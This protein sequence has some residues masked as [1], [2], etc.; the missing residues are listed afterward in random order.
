MTQTCVTLTHDT[1]PPW[2]DP[3]CTVWVQR[4]AHNTVGGSSQNLSSLFWKLFI[5]KIT[6]C[7][8]CCRSCPAV[9]GQPGPAE[10]LAECW[11]CPDTCG[12]TGRQVFLSPVSI[13][14]QTT[15]IVISRHPGHRV[16]SSL[17]WHFHLTL[18]HTKSICT[19]PQMSRATEGFLSWT[20]KP[21]SVRKF[22]LQNENYLGGIICVWH[23]KLSQPDLLSIPRQAHIQ[24]LAFIQVL[25]STWHTSPLSSPGYVQGFLIF[26]QVKWFYSSLR[27]PQM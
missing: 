21:S 9:W 3:N 7:Q 14:W 4:M 10:V 6:N 20:T 5:S 19:L 11:P 8:T 22:Y 17:V 23:G 15:T 27:K 12:I 2:N 1:I 18:S 26:W 24:I 25:A 16:N 13:E